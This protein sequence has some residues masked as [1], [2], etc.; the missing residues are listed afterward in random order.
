MAPSAIRIDGKRLR[1]DRGREVTFRGINVSGDAKFPRKPNLP[2]H[3]QGDFFDGDNVSFVGRPFNE[4]EAHMHF[5]RLKRWGYNSIRYVFTWEAIEHAGPGIYDDEFVQSTINTLRIAKDYGFHIFMDPH[6]D[7]WSRHSGGDGAPMWT[8]YAAGFDPTHFSK[9][10]AA[11]VHSAWPDPATFP[12]MLWPTNYQRLVAF[13]MFTLFWAGKDFAPKAVIDG[14]N[15]QDYLQK[16]FIDACCYLAQKIHEAGDLED[17]CVIGWETMNEPARGLVGWEHLDAIPKELNMKK[18]TCPTPWQSLL[19]GSGRAVEVDTYEFGNFGPYKSGTLLIDPEGTSAWLSPESS[20]DEKYG[21]KRDSDWELG[22]CLWAQ[23][24]VW[25]PKTDSL[26]QPEY[27]DKLPKTGDKLTYEKFTNTYFLQHVRDY[28]LNIRNRHKDCIILLQAPVLEIPPSIKGTSDED[29]RLIFAT[30][31]YDGLTLLTKHWNRLYN[32]DVFGVLRGKYWSP[33]FAVKVGETAIRNCLRSQLEAI[34]TE[35]EEH[36]GN[37][38]TLFT[39]IGIPY[40]MDDKHAYKTGD[41]SSQISALD[42]N[43]FALE[44]SG[45]AGYTLWLYCGSNNHQWGDNW[46][47]E[48]LSI[49]SVDDHIPASQLRDEP[50]SINASSTTLTRQDSRLSS[51]VRPENLKSK[52]VQPSIERVAAETPPDLGV[53]GLRA[54]E[55]FLRPSPIATH[56]DVVKYGFD[57]KSATFMLSLSA[58][59]KTPDDAPTEIFLPDFH[60]PSG[61]TSVEVSGGKWIIETLDVD[62]EGMQWM[63][64]WHAEGEQTMKVTGVIRKSGQ[65][66]GVADEDYGYFEVM[67]RISESCTVM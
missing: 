30:H 42:A 40:D 49:M 4:D 41:Y 37:H 19:T 3:I 52:L 6:Q 23:H 11:M 22:T 59:S 17:V 50:P 9:T 43:H 36:I 45:A 48:D 32:V 5:A 62:G 38:P 64:W 63:K 35:G 31:Y 51:E 34:R 7:V 61:K 1:D 29:N 12:K 46:N 65:T 10:Q 33:A 21:W 53:P 57:L 14:Q 56:G 55:A 18:G 16:H 15:I 39:E 8:L 58:P 25:D 2:T 60:F 28:K 67:K 66:T 44:G 13:T 24:G 27:F 47:G 54:A 26:L 20:R